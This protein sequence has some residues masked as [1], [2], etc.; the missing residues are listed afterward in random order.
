[1]FLT[2]QTS[3]HPPVS[4]F[5]IHCPQRGITARGFDQISAR[6][7]GTGIRIA[8]GQHNYGIFVTLE[9][10][11]H[12]EYRLIHPAAHLGGLLRGSLTISVADTCSLTCSKTGLKTILRYHPDGWVGRSQHRIDG[13]VFRYDGADDHTTAIGDVPPQGILARIHGSWHDRIYYTLST[14]PVPQLLIDISPLRPIPK[15]APPEADQLPNESRRF[16]G[17]V[18]A[19]IRDRRFGHATKLKQEIEERQ[20]QKAAARKERREEWKPRFF[21]GAVTPP[22]KPELTE[23]GIRAM[24]GLMEGNFHLDESLETGA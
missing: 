18:T 13:V 9:Q 7:T 5:Y 22:G 3:H 16:W 17:P 12:E 4:A 14:D 24:Q 20:R 21:T 1:V 10:R 11:D 6:F 8:P 19:A 2:E 15:D 23:E